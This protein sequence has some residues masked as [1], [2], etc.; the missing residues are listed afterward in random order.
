[1]RPAQVPKTG[2]SATKA[3]RASA[4]PAGFHELAYSRAFSP[5]DDEPVKTSQICG[6]AHLH[7]LGAQTLEH[8]DVFS[9]GALQGKD[10][11]L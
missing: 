5:G 6:Q 8:V 2:W 1:M 4:K 7:R 11:D 10:T 3:R 9:K